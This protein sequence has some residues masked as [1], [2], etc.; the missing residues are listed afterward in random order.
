MPRLGQSGDGIHGSSGALT[1]RRWTLAA[2]VF[3]HLDCLAQRLDAPTDGV[4][5]VLNDVEHEVGSVLF[6]IGRRVRRSGSRSPWSV[7]HR[8]E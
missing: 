3:G 4:G 6:R 5:A 7:C 2:M 8:Y 1:S